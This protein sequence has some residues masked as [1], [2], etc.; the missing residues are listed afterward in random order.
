MDFKEFDG[1]HI[2]EFAIN[3][4]QRHVQQMKLQKQKQMKAQRNLCIVAIILSIATLL[5]NCA[6]FYSMKILAETIVSG[7]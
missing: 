1:C 6:L 7:I 2:P 4:Q 5:M 3:A